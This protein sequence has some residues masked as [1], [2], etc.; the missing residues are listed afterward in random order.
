MD[1]KFKVLADNI[2]TPGVKIEKD[3]VH[4]G[5]CAKGMAKP[6]L[7]LYPKGSEEIAAV[8]PF[9]NEAA[10]G[11]F[12]SM[13]VRLPA[14][15]YE[16]NFREGDCVVTDPY[17]RCIVGREQFGSEVLPSGHSVRGSFLT[18]SFD[19]GE[20]RC[21][22]IPFHEMVL[23]HLHVRGY[24]M[25]K[26]SGVRHKGTFAGLQEKLPYLQELG[27]NALKLMP[28]YE[29][30]ELRPAHEKHRKPP[31][32]QEEAKARALEQEE[33]PQPHKMNFW[34]YGEGFYFAP[35]ASYAFGSHPAEEFKTL[36]KACHEK[37][38]EVILEFSFT[39]DTDFC[40]IADCLQ[41]WATEYHVD[42]FSVI[43]RE[44]IVPELAKLPLFSKRKLICG[45]YPEAVVRQNA[46]DQTRLLGASNDGFMNDCRR[47]LKGEDAFLG[48]FGYRT[49]QNPAG[50]AQINYITNHD[51]FTLADLVSYEHKYNASNGEM[52]RDG[53]DYNY[54]WNC[55]AEGP[56]KRRDILRLRLQQR[57]NAYA[58]MLFSQGTPMLLAG[59]E[60]GNSQDGNNNP[61]CHD[62][63]LSWTDWSHK[64]S[65]TELTSFVR[66]AIAFR[67]K[68][69][70]LHQ[71]TELQC[72][73]H[74]ASGFPDLSYHSDRA[75]YGD[76]DRM[77][78][79]IGCMYAGDYVG[80]E[81]FLYLA[82]NF[83]WDSQSFAL[84]LLPK[85]NRWHVV[86]DTS[87]KNSFLEQDEQMLASDAKCYTVPPRAVVILEGRKT[88]A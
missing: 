79:H 59:D 52:E 41:Y 9:E 61:Y 5:Y 71:E 12:F 3:G 70:V 65:S 74:H 8:L 28:V 38:M 86:M 64:K 46:E 43:A 53:T 60:I 1:S 55:G 24:T 7:L 54:S 48:A 80:E 19:W 82:W 33:A 88:D 39:D 69:K 21:P 10:P 22:E 13:K 18:R 57:K 40:T 15:K 35:K 20:D 51:G 11:G 67:K 37:E 50:C 81:G 29:F 14:A 2:P 34:G 23:Y 63:I 62:S 58:M 36:V 25:Q 42:G 68:H 56:T 31:K 44:N 78:L 72:T 73:D 6:E 17:A 27:I 49:R 47:L 45:W 83:H 76:F 30:P 85:Q 84:P 4:F 16:Y 87:R 26:N 32:S 75:W 66:Q 77:K